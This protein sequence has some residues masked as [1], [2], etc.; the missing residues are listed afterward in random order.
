MIFEKLP[1]SEDQTPAESL[2][3]MM[4]GYRMT[5]LVY[6]AAELGIADYLVDS[7]KS[8]AK[9]A[10]YI[11]ADKEN[12]HRIMRALVSIGLFDLNDSDEYVLNSIS[13]L[14]CQNTEGSLRNF[15][16]RHG[17]PWS[18]LPWGALI[19]AIRTGE[20]A[21]EHV[22]GQSHWKYLNNHPDIQEGFSCSM[23][24]STAMLSAE[25]LDIV[26]FPENSTVIDVGGGFGFLLANIL[27]GYPTV[28]GV[29]LEQAEVVQRANEILEQQNVMHRCKLVSG[30]FF[31]EVPQRGDI[32]I[33]Q[34]IIHDWEDTKALIILRNCRKVM[35][36]K[37][38]L[39]IIE[40]IMPNGPSPSPVKIVDISVMVLYGSGKERTELEIRNL[41]AKADLEISRILPLPTPYALIE[42]A[43]Y[44]LIEVVPN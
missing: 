21:F 20:N 29:I 7:P 40:R 15:A 10:T 1:F 6:V 3:W 17:A 4:M 35:G 25:I 24:E 34:R 30:D 13:Q 11:E 16:I 27:K 41:L 43:G 14:L 37:S 38:R 23:A 36:E 19:H 8:I 12:L 26:D 5:Q 44:S 31:E 33:L 2:G 18:W 28:T 39:L 32:Y 9:L 42:T 22:F